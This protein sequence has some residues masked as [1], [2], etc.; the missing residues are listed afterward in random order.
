[1]CRPPCALS[2]FSFARSVR[3]PCLR[4]ADF[5]KSPVWSPLGAQKFGLTSYLRKTVGSVSGFKVKSRA[6]NF[7]VFY[8]SLVFLAQSRVGLGF[9][10]PQTNG[11]LVP[12]DLP[13]PE[14]FGAIRSP[15][16]DNP[17]ISAGRFWWTLRAK[18]LLNKIYGMFSFIEA[19]CPSGDV[20]PPRASLDGRVRARAEL[21]L[22]QVRRFTRASGA[23]LAGGHLRVADVLSNINQQYLRAPSTVA[24]EV[25]P[26]AIDLPTIA[27][28]LYI[29]DYLFGSEKEQYENPAGLVMPQAD[30]ETMPPNQPRRRGS[31]G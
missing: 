11:P 12:S 15:P 26:D 19:G 27:G 4:N 24:E 1:M 13:F 29:G 17:N 7:D 14:I 2:E 5:L 28:S 6:T 21:H 20:A 23:P 9:P 18:S 22:G 8:T 25:V 3:K 16:S 10:P 30:P 31:Y